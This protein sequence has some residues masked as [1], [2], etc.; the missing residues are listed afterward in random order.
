MG[1]NRVV[2]ANLFALRRVFPSCL[3]ADATR[4]RGQRPQSHL[5]V[6]LEASRRLFKPLHMLPKGLFHE[7]PLL[8]SDQPVR[9]LSRKKC[10]GSNDIRL[11]YNKII[12]FP[13]HFLFFVAIATTK[14]D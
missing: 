2:P 12:V 14:L 4:R 7:M 8:L 11:L 5:D 13:L 6:F 3:L 1:R 9:M 10:N